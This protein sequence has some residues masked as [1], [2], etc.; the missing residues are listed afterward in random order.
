MNYTIVRSHLKRVTTKFGKRVRPVKRHKRSKK[1]KRGSPKLPFKKLRKIQHTIYMQDKKT[2]L[3]KGR[4]RAHG[5]GDRT[6][7]LIDTNTYRIFGRTPKPKKHRKSFS[8][9]TN[10]G[11]VSD[12]L[13]KMKLEV[14]HKKSELASL[15]HPKKTEDLN[16]FI[17]R[18]ALIEQLTKQ[19]DNEET[20]IKRAMGRFG[21]GST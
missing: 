8:S 17:K 5:V 18:Q 2:G 9:F 14:H 10:L 3:M 11:P 21:Y 4:K 6:G 16:E 7:L 19:I 12:S 15:S 1:F 13:E 20:S